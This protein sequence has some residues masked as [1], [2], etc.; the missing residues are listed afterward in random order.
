M[1]L[2]L[3]AVA[4][5]NACTTGATLGASMAHALHERN[6]A[7]RTRAPVAAVGNLDAAALHEHREPVTLAAYN[8]GDP[9]AEV[10]I[11]RERDRDIA[12]RQGSERVLGG[13]YK[14]ISKKKEKE[15]KEKTHVDAEVLH[16]A[17]AG[18]LASGQRDEASTARDSHVEL[19]K[20]RR[21]SDGGVA[22]SR[23]ATQPLVP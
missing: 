16:Q 3:S 18:L 19:P 10:D 5:P 17:T 4:L 23:H 21:Y 6:T 9:E 11:E 20:G 15:Q 2:T 22:P 13:L 14:M 7:A 8:L 1:V 12:R